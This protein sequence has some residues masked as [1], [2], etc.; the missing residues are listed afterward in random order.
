MLKI[1]LILLLLSFGLFAKA[2]VYKSGTVFPYY[3]DIN[4]DT[5]FWFGPGSNANNHQTYTFNIDN[6]LQAEFKIEAY[7]AGGIGGGTRWIK[8]IPTDTN[9]FVS[10]SRIDSVYVGQFGYW[11]TTPMARP[12][13]YGDSINSLS[14]KWSASGLSIC[15]NTGSGAGAAHPTDWV[16]TNDYYAGI[17]YQNLSDTLYGWVR[18]NCPYST[19]CYLKDYSFSKCLSSPVLTTLSSASVSCA[20]DQVSINVTGA[21]SY[22]WSTG[23]TDSTLIVSPNITT[24]YTVE[25]TNAYGCPATT[26]ITQ[27]VANLPSLTIT[28]STNVSCASEP[29]TITVNGAGSYTWSTG[30]TDSTLTV[31]PG[32]TTTYTV[33]GM[34]TY[35]CIGTAAITQSV[36]TCAGIR[37][38]NNYGINLYPN[39][40]ATMLYIADPENRFTK[41]DTEVINYL[42]QCVSLQEYTDRIDVSKL[43]AGIYTLII[44]TQSNKSYYSKF[45]KE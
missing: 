6:D 42:G 36:I 12:L 26:A 5:M 8:I 35:G 31:A 32:T 45:I 34:N 16:S 44:K 39:P 20:S 11:I 23:S 43:Q 22:T 9:C 25:G 1:K 14:A 19:R 27:N 17:K 3:Y 21:A 38:Y 15:D 30:S 4:P 33:E 2:Q 24:S 40:T 7:S 41:A 37:E 10:F 29:V 13:N 28:S 18:V